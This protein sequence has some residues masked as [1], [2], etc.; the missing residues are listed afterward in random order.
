MRRFLTASCLALALFVALA[1]FT[2]PTARAQYVYSYYAPA[3]VVTV[4]PVTTAYYVP[5]A[6]VYSYSFYTPTVSYY[7]APVVAYS[8]PTVAYYP[9][10]ATPYYYARPRAYYRATSYYAPYYGNYY[11]SPRY[12]R[13]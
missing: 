1:A 13:Y 10:V 2:P 11:Y 5:A 9:P 4:A 7:A 8:A 6:P 3:P 12:Y